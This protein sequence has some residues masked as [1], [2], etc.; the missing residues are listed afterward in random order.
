M[1]KEFLLFS[2]LNEQKVISQLV[3]IEE[4]VL[5]HG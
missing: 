4:L 1:K 3:L 5:F 2:L